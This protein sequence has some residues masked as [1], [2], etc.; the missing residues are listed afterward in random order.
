MN[1]P[2]LATL[3]PLTIA[4]VWHGFQSLC[5]EMR[6]MVT[7][8]AQSYL[9]ATLK[10]LSVGVWLADGSTVA[11]PEGLPG[12]FLGT[13]FAIQAIREKFKDDLHPGD[14]ILTNDPYHGGHNSHLP[15]W[16]FIRPIFFEGELLFFTMVRGH[17]QD[18]GGSFPGGYF[19]NAY[20][21]I[22]E[23]LCIPPL[24]VVKRGV[25]DADLNALIYNNVRF[26]TE[27]KIDAN[28]MIATA[29]FAENRIVQLLHRYGRDTVIGAIHEMMDRTEKAVRAE[30]AA[31][32]DGT[33]SGDSSTDDDGTVLDEPVTVR[34]DVTIK[35][36]EITMD[37]SR[38]DAQ[39]TG[40]VN[41]VYAVTY[42]RAVAAVIVYMDP[43]LADF[44][45]TGSMR[46]IKVIAPPGSVTNAQYPA[47]VGA[48]PVNVGGQVVEACVEALGKARPDRS[49]A[50]WGKHRGDYTFGVDPRTEER[51]VRTTFDYDGSAGAVWGHD[52]MTGPTTLTTLGSV[53]RGSLEEAEIRYPWRMLK[54]EARPNFNGAGRWRGGGGIDWRALNEGSAGRM[55]TG[56]SDGDFIQVKGAQGGQPN[57][58]SRTIIVRGDQKI[59]VKPHRMAEIKAGDI[60][61]KLSAGGAGVGDPFERPVDKVVTDVRREMVTVEGARLLYG[62]VI[63]PATLKVDE[64]ATRKLRSAPPERRYEAVINED[65][66]DIELKPV[67]EKTGSAA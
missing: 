34:V 4:T 55:A 23:G 48:S 39:R 8:T 51:Y 46:P 41:C 7:R 6:S 67:G 37:F 27:I 38:S 10:D 64:E 59:R 14:V 53:Q 13:Q 26:P 47:T 19:A 28:A 40:F 43:A 17:M 66:L 22:A 20:D 18:T 57:P 63:D 9:M 31:M 33:Y 45:N 24:K 50:S 21:I 54:L 35:G 65:L 11:V 52:G 1:K 25:E 36:D 42:A 2:A 61:V 29:Q 16:G 60:V 30:I 58:C 44:H 3:D 62:V 56:S 5:R 49:I 12:Q 32:P 15:D